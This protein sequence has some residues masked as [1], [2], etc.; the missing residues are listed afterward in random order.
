MRRNTVIISAGFLLALAAGY[1][2]ARS[3]APERLPKKTAGEGTRKAA[4]R[5]G[6]EE[7]EPELRSRNRPA[8]EPDMEAHN[9]NA[10]VGQR[11]LV[12]RDRAAM[13]AFLAKAGNKI[14]IMGRIDALNA[15][16]VSFLNIAD[17]NDLLDGTEQTGM[18]FP[19]FLPENES[20]AAQAGAVPM[21]NSLLGWLGIGADG[22]QAG[23]GVRIAIL[24]TGVYLHSAFGGQI[25][26]MGAAGDVNGHGTAVAGQIL[27]KTA[28]IPGVAS[29]GTVLSYQIA[30][31]EGFSDSF[32]IA[33]A[34]MAA[35][36]DGANIIN[37]SMGSRYQ[38]DLLANA[39]AEAVKAGVV[40]VAAAGN[41]GANQVY[42]PAAYE[43]VVAVGAVDKNGSWLAFSN[44]GST[45]DAAAPGYGLNAAWPNDGAVSISGTSFSAPI[46]AGLIART[47]SDSG[48]KLSAVQAWE[49]VSANLNDAGAPG[50][51]PQYGMGIPDMSRVANA[52]TKGIYDA[53]VSSHW[54]TNAKGYTEL[55][56]T[57]Q[58]RGTETLINA[59]VDVSV[60]SGSSHFNAT[61]LAAGD[62]QTFSVPLSS[63]ITGSG[64]AI[65]LE[66]QVILSGGQTDIKPSNNRRVEIFTP[67][68][69]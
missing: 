52:G 19:V 55:Q 11:S 61:T 34:I 41:A 32:R 60:A 44:S 3:A 37:I 56:V 24:D 29:N 28:T 1:L 43:G 36:A 63:R 54:V 10:I 57:I 5:Q 7:P 31:A 12:F 17:L 30:D 25:I 23:A 26:A 53:A 49:L 67:A 8:F 59:G 58:N 47:M 18:I 40:V 21:G 2:V 65:R 68:K 13:N 66:S 64:E 6:I 38:S 27:G 48:G 14:R 22:S 33:E 45:L 4:P 15:L 42:Y 35:I 39:V 62:I 20:V 69:N 16:R 50:Q 9:A 51:D 46:I